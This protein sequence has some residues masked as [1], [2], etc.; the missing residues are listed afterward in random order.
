MI[1][2][3]KINLCTFEKNRVITVERNLSVSFS[4]D[5]KSVILW[6]LDLDDLLTRGCDWLK[7]YLASHPNAPKVCPSK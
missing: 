5:G 1:G 4:P 6:S 3:S 7:P 2:I